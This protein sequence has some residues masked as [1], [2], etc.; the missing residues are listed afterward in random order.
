MTGAL[1]KKK[2]A[3]SRKSSRD[4]RYFYLFIL[5]W[6]IGF[7]GLTIGPMLYSLFGSFCKW[8]G[9][10]APQY[11]GIKNFLK[12][13][14]FDELFRK[15]ML[16]TLYYVVMAVPSSLLLSLLLAFLINGKH[17][18][19]GVFQA[20]FYFPSVS[21]GIAVYMVWIW[22]FN[23]E[24]GV[25]N[26]FLSL[27]GIQGPRWLSDPNVSMF[28]LV[29]M[30][31]TFCGGQ[32]LIFLAGLKQIPLA[33]YEAA[34]ID[35]ANG[36]QKFFKI[37]LP[38][39]SPTILFNGIMGMIG[40]FQIFGQALILTEGGPVQSTYVMGLF[41]YKSA[42]NYGKFGYASAASWVM[43]VVLM[44]LSFIVM[45]LSEKHVNYEM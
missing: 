37:T 41:I 14:T 19:T 34:T 32:M 29:I 33:Y 8:D 10:S 44:L 17:K 6:L 23:S 28:T 16:N 1:S 39:L 26:Y 38:M 11:I 4:N 42:F 36:F 9:I 25:F 15:T 2:H 3:S 13:F 31:L 35:G 27:L 43:F 5:P 20:I 21:A 7:F 12:L 40:A 22:F 30:N 24:V 45:R 18:F